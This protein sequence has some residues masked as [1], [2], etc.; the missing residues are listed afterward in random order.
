[1]QISNLKTQNYNL[2]F[3][4]IFFSFCIIILIFAFWILNF[5]PLKGRGAETNPLD[6]FAKCLTERGVVMYG[7]YWCP[8][9][10]NE[11]KAFGDSFKFVNYVE[12]T[13]ETQK[14]LAEN[15]E[16]YPTWIFPDGKRLLGEQGIQKLA[17]A[18]GCVLPK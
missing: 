18:S 5:G 11:K 7:A 15:I 16:G 17:Q 14:C 2:K 10:Q 4:I 1:M 8:H 3:K 13:Q 6:D 9:C 12:C